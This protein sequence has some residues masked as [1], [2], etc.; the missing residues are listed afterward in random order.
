MDRPVIIEEEL[1]CDSIELKAVIVKIAEVAVEL[2]RVISLGKKDQL[3]N[4]STGINTDGDDQKT[5]DVLADEAYMQN[6]QNTDVRLYVSEEEEVV[7]ELNKEGCIAIAINPLDGSSNIDTNVSIGSI[8]SIREIE[9]KRA[10]IDED[11]NKTFLEP[12]SKQIGAGYIIFGP[13]TIM[14]LTLGEGVQQYTLDRDLNS[15]FLIDNIG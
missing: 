3:L 4:E 12:G 9:S 5:L 14:V 7:V 11:L 10:K 15:F 13:Q 1:V 6:L 2:S 8:F